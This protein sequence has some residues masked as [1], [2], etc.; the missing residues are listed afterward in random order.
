[1]TRAEARQVALGYVRSKV[2]NGATRRSIRAVSHEGFGS[3]DEPGYLF[4]HG[5]I[6]VPGLPYK[7][8]QH[9]FPTDELI[10]ELNVGQGDLFGVTA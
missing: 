8:E 5:R 1:M 6:T 7:G 10:D 4:S 9:T 2:I 3:P